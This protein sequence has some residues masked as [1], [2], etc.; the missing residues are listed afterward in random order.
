MNLKGISG[1]LVISVI[2]IMVVLMLI[3]PLPTAVLDV[4]IT[5][6]IVA[7]ITV[8]LVATSAKDAL[9]FSTFPT[10][11][12]ILTVYRIAINISTTR[13]I[14]G[15]GGDAGQLVRTFGLFVGGNDIVIGSVI[16]L[17]LILVQF[18]VI[19]R[20]AER[21]SEVAA[22]FTLDAM[23][24]KQM[25]IDADLNS[26]TIDEAEARKRRVNVAREADFYGSMDGASKFVKGD[27]ILGILATAINVIAGLIINSVRGGGV[28]ATVYIIAAIGDGLAAQ[29]P[30][31]LISTATGIIVTKAAT[32]ESLGADIARQFTAEPYILFVGGG[33]I[34]LLSF[35]PNMPMLTMWIIGIALLGMGLLLTRSRQR[36][37]VTE[38]PEPIEMEAQETRKP[39]NVVSLLQVDPIELMFGYGII[40][41]AEPS[42]GGDLLDRVVMIRRQ[43]ATELGLIVPVIRMR[44]DIRF[45][46]NEYSIKIKGNEVARGEIMLDH[47]LAM[48]PGTVDEEISGIDTI[49]PAF[50]LP[51]KWITAR[52]REKAE[53]YGYTI[54]D[55]PSVIAT[56]MTEIV[57]SHAHELLGRQQV[58]ALVDNLKQTQPSLVE[59]V[60]PK[61]FTLG[62]LQKVLGNLLRE[63]VSIRDMSTIVETLGDYGS[64]TRDSDMLTEYVRQ[65][66][67]RTITAK[68]APD[69]K[70]HVISIT[71]ELENK[72]LE[73]IRQTEHGSYVA[74]EADEIQQIFA[75]LR[76]AVERV[77]GLGIAPIVLCSPV[78]R[79]HFKRMVEGLAPDLVVLSY[80]ELMQNTDIQA[81]GMVTL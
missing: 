45:A 21:V 27:N 73:S 64:V 17:L 49:E 7:A 70:V 62:E 34:M 33:V 81:D 68:F 67:K 75:S 3:I 10:V 78:V 54:V 71:P 77:Q 35:I 50:G 65:A 12:L 61:M 1:N 46:N 51:A 16:F 30:A 69:G 48:N 23:P 76:N 31:M 9:G 36:A 6:N 53:L 32:D 18:L 57:R 14:L 11:L 43:C 42:Q 2:V 37:A 56:H 47:Y 24:G 22:R 55:P 19:T 5:L 39:D 80:N 4:L 52:E 8:I 44:D 79:F 40:P 66:L 72:I 29:I 26:G 13:Q 25:A 28:D 74:L 58:Q 41:L 63:G 15:N 59:E 60:I 38:S 20:G